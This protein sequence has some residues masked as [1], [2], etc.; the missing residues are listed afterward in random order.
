M[1]TIQKA[2]LIAHTLIAL[3]IIILVLLQRGKGADAGVFIDLE[4]STRLQLT[5]T[6]SRM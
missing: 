5:V 1:D 2:V 3:M 4:R 6:Y